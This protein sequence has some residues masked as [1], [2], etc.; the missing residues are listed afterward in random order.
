MKTELERYKEALNVALAYLKAYPS[1]F[2]EPLRDINAILNP[3]PEMETIEVKRWECKTCGEMFK[4]Q[5]VNG[6]N[7][8]CWGMDTLIPLTGTF[9]RPKAQPVERSV[10]VEG[11][12]NGLGSLSNGRHGDIFN[13]YHE[14]R[15][16][17]GVVTFTWQE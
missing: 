14:C 17:K 2:R 11:Y 4:S 1:S 3:P 7:P 16:K 15:G 6:G 12:V 10:S 13:E 5:A 9:Q 8:C